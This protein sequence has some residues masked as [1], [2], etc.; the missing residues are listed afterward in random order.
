M[1]PD[2]MPDAELENRLARDL[3]ALHKDQQ[4]QYLSLHNNYGGK[5]VFGGIFKTNSLPCGSG[6]SATAVFPTISLI[7][8]SCLPNSHYNWNDSLEM[9]TVHVTRTINAGEEITICYTD[10]GSTRIRQAYL[11]RHFGFDCSCEVCSLSIVDRRASDARREQVTRL[12]EIFSV[13][14]RAKSKPREALLDLRAILKSSN[15]VRCSV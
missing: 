1:I 9:E 7:N 3:K 4:R 5:Y 11:K 6:P 14:D 15:D 2:H 8:H 12:Q 13:C 10:S